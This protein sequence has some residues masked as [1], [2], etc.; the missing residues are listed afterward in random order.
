LAP[1]ASGVLAEKSLVLGTWRAVPGDRSG[2]R[3]A[4]RSGAG[5][6]ASGK[7]SARVLQVRAL[8]AHGEGSIVRQEG[9]NMIEI[10]LAIGGA[11]AFAGFGALLFS[12]AFAIWRDVR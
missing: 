8:E 11:L 7:Q 2:S 1:G 3:K 4:D 12:M 6:A 10:V 9:E 5:V